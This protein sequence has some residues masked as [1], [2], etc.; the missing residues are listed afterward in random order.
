MGK[1]S[2]EM[3]ESNDEASNKKG[4]SS[5]NNSDDMPLAQKQAASPAL[6]ALTKQQ[7]M[8]TSNKKGEEQD[9]DVEMRVGTLLATVA[10]VEMVTSGGVVEGGQEVKEE[11]MEVEKDEESNE[12]VGT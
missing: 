6:V 10:K 2:R 9:E 3:V 5:S 11:A 1:K 8:V 7:K 12:E 4:N